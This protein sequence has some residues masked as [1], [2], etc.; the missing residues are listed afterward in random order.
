MPAVP[1]GLL[2]NSSVCRLLQ[3]CPAVA[4]WRLVVLTR[5]VVLVSDSFPGPDPT[6]ELSDAKARPVTLLC[7]ALLG[8]E[9][10]LGAVVD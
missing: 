2:S 1:K 3:T 7:L 9:Q 6:A 5:G 8:L 4:V 10:A